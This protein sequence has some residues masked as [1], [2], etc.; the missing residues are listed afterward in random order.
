MLTSI[1]CARP[2]ECDDHDRPEAH[3]A[4]YY[5]SSR[6]CSLRSCPTRSKRGRP[7]ER[8]GRDGAPLRADEPDARP[9]PPGAN[10]RFGSAHRDA[11]VLLVVSTSWPTDDDLAQAVETRSSASRR[12]RALSHPLVLATQRPSVDVITGMIKANVPSRSRSPSR[13]DGLRV[14]LDQSAPRPCSARVTCCSSRSTS[15]SSA[16]RGRT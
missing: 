16:S 13:A 9:Q 8:G 1:C 5:E 10:R 6:T 2:D 15:V 11:A 7:H 12:S 14:I 3:R 4:R